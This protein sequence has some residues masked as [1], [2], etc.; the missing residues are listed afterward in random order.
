MQF[1]GAVAVVTGAA[2]GIG[3]ALGER[4]HDAGATVVV[5]DRPGTGVERLAAQLNARRSGSAHAVI[6]DVSR[7]E[8]NARLVDEARRLAGRIDLFF[9]NAGVA[10][11]G[12][13][14]ATEPDWMT[15]F[16]VNVHAHR[17]AAK[18]LLPEWLA[19]GRGYFA[20]TA[21]AAGLLAQIGSAP[22]SVTKHAAVAFAEWL[23]ITYGSRGLRVSCLC[24]QGVNTAM[25]RGGDRPNG[26]PTESNVVRAVGA[27]LEPSTVADIVHDAL[28]EERFFILPHPEVAEY[29][30][31]KATEHERWLGGMRKLQR[32]VFGV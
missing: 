15:S 10:L 8:D 11:G 5:S 25:L 7:E 12:D 17:W 22:Y 24:P 18:Y 16:D 4:F 14:T 6:A 20:S 28:V 29:M 3:S 30:K 32:R 31:V 27:V 2:G 19:A 26:E 1:A 13:L 9:A 21:S 23:S